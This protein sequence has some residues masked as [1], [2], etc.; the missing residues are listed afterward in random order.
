[1]GQVDAL[2]ADGK[3]VT[4]RARFATSPEAQQI[5]SDVKA[6][7]H[8]SLS[9]GYQHIGEG[10][11][12][13]AGTVYR[14]APHEVSIVPVPADT[15]A[16][17]Y[18]SL[19]KQMTPTTAPTAP[20]INRAA[21]QAEIMELGKRHGLT[22]F[23]RGLAQS[24][25]DI[26][27]ARTAILEELGARDLAAGGHRNTN[28][29][30]LS[31]FGASGHGGEREVLIASLAH[32]M[33]ARRKDQPIL[34]GL[35]AVG[36]AQRSLE[37]AGER[38]YSD[39]SRTQIIER[40]MHGT[41]D[42]PSLLGAAAGRVLLDAYAAAPAALKA[43]ARE[44]MLPDFR[45]RTTVRLGSA[46][47]LEQVN[48]HGEFHYGTIEEGAAA[49]RLVTYGRIFA[50]TRQALVN[51]DLG[52]FGDLVRLFAEA[53]ARREADELVKALTSPGQ[54]DGA[55]L[56]S[57]A[58]NTQS[59]RK[60]TLAGLGVAVQALRGQKHFDQLV[61]QEPGAIVVPAAL[62]M[63]ARQ[64]V[65]SISATK[66]TDVQPFGALSVVVEPRLTDA[67]EWYL[68]AANQRAL[69][70]GYLDGEAGPQT[71]QREGFEIDGLEVKARL[72]FGCGW[73]SPVGWVQNTGATGDA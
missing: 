23:A 56:F 68:V 44:T 41:G 17:F 69:E 33:G 12:T 65:A 70:Y 73:V 31:A 47:S 42:F 52:A 59:P 61:T 22:D 34:R 29:R 3:R 24:A 49:W 36:L 13:D 21:L 58:R 55:A 9:V 66:T 25:T 4:G 46:P 5:L 1:M 45:D 35:D 2:A 16:G 37:L 30:E 60:L 7:F 10:V 57:S 39:M 6:G 20:T 27:A 32:R 40:A 54:V 51:D 15:G 14:W 53:A 28:S 11:P 19:D 63:T 8:R 62:E 43:V 71:S 72:D 38:V 48:E 67:N 18:R 50:I 26:G 64:L